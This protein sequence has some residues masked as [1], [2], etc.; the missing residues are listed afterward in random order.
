MGG[1]PHHSIVVGG[2]RRPELWGQRHDSGGIHYFAG[3]LAAPGGHADADGNSRHQRGRGKRLLVPAHRESRQRNGD[4]F[5]HRNA[6]LGIV[7]R[8][9]RRVD[10]QPHQRR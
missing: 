2:L 7:Q 4:V 6:C 3:I 10:R 9:Y 1:I 8:D 5:D